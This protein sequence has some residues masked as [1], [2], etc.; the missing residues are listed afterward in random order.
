MAS[1]KL[2][3]RVA[4]TMR[5]ADDA[6][7]RRRRDS[8]LATGQMTFCRSLGA[9]ASPGF[10]V[11]GGTT[12]DAPKARAS[13]RRVGWG[14]ERG[15]CSAADYGVWG[16]VVSSPSEVRGGASAAIAFSAYFK[17]QDT[18]GSKKNTACIKLQG[19]RAAVPHAW[20]RHWLVADP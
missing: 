6:E 8:A 11:R 2:R 10:G 3:R 13:R 19:A 20:R 4:G 5:S 15:V 1:D 17:P 14:T 7:R 16:S 9:V 18:S 12:I